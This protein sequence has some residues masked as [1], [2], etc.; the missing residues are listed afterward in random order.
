MQ[1]FLP[2]IK[3]TL[4]EWAQL[5]LANP[6]YA[7]ALVIA[8]GVLAAIVSSVKRIPLKRKAAASEKACTEL[9]NMLS[10]AQQQAVE[11]QEQLAQRNQQ[12]AGTL[13]ALAASFDLGLPAGDDL[14]ADDLWRQH[15]RAIAE[16]TARLRAEQQAKVEFQQAYQT[17]TGKL[18]EKETLLESLQN[19]LEEKILQVSGLEQQIAEILEQHAV[20]SARLVELEQQTLEW[21]K[22][23]QQLEALEEK[24]NVK[25]AEFSQL[26]IQAEAQKEAELIESQIHAELAKESELIQ[27]QIP[28]E[29]EQAIAQSPP[30]IEVA[31]EAQDIQQ[32][33][34]LP[35]WESEP[36]AAVAPEVL[37]PGK[38][39]SKSSGVGGLFKNLF[40]KSK[41]EPAATVAEKAEIPSTKVEIQPEAIAEEQASVSFAQGQIGKIKSLF[42]KSKPDTQAIDAEEAEVAETPQAAIQ[43]GHSDDGERS[44]GSAQ[45]QFGKI[46]SLLGLSR[47]ETAIAE[48]EE[49]V[50]A[51]EAT[52]ASEAANAGE[53]SV[54]VV[55]SPI[56]KIKNLFGKAK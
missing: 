49:P 8:T 56:G 28:V 34:I 36:E 15:D 52:A 41:S 48:A 55:K 1:E 5:T 46:K 29:I 30:A 14:Q 31:M 35:D 21:L 39:V 6:L 17:E 40:G 50:Q 10:L 27:P 37:Q 16:M 53:P 47:Q 26:Q 2:I 32:T 9:S 7:A 38:A 4:L 33:I 42:G 51:E 12:I 23:R 54:S 13:Q 25:E 3:A 45:S 19:T 22:T 18:A 44:A 11:L 20:K 24:L 43:F